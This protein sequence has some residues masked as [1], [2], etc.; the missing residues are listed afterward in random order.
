MQ[1]EEIYEEM[2]AIIQGIALK[3]ELLDSLHI[4]VSE[5]DFEI[6]LN[7][8]SFPTRIKKAIVEKVQE[9]EEEQRKISIRIQ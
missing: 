5:E 3:K 9:L 1:H 4:A 2:T 6:Y 7:L 8:F